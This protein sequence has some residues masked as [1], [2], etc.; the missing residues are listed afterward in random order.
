MNR[1]NGHI[2]FL[3]LSMKLAEGAL[4]LF[5]VSILKGQ[6]IVARYLEDEA[7]MQQHFDALFCLPQFPEA[8]PRVL[9][10]GTYVGRSEQTELRDDLAAVEPKSHRF[11]AINKNGILLKVWK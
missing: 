9:I 3:R 7:G 1:Q 2:V 4:G 6:V 11:A 8:R 10:A 5:E